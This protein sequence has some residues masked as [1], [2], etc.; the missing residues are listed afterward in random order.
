[1]SKKKL[2]TK[3]EVS[4][5]I[6][7]SPMIDCCFLLLIFFVVNAT[8]ITVSKDP[9]V[10]MP[11]AVSCT[12]LK[13]AKGCIVVNVF[14]DVE[15]MKGNALNKFTTTYPSGTYWGV[16]EAGGK[17]IGYTSSQTQELTDF[18]SKQKDL[19]KNQQKIEEK[20]IRLY[21]R[22]DQNAPWERSATAIRCAAA[23]GVNNIVFGTL[24][25]K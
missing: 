20:N 3:E 11:S 13:D 5:D 21:L 17:S 1:M 6:N 9:S 22:G 23:A 8:Q 16:A 25:S 18:I 2:N 24:P 10:G 4:A 7:L 15:N 14:A 19:F 12:E